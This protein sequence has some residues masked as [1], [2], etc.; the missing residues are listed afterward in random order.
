MNRVSA[1]DALAP[2]EAIADGAPERSGGATRTI[3]VE[4]D[5]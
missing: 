3:S 4:R 2:I 5:D 1:A